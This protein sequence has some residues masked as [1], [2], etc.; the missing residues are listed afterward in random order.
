ML[1]KKKKVKEK[2]NKYKG[3]KKK[4]ALKIFKGGL[5]EPIEYFLGVNNGKR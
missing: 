4:L 5:S 3:T 2:K 1:R